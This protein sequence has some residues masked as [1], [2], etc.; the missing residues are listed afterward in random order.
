MMKDTMEYCAVSPEQSFLR[1][2]LGL[3]VC[4]MFVAMVFLLGGTL[5]RPVDSAGSLTQF[6]SES[7]AGFGDDQSGSSPIVHASHLQ[8]RESTGKPP[9]LIAVASNFA[10]PVKDLAKRFELHTGVRL[11]LTFGSTGK[12]FT[13]VMNG[14]PFDA[15]L[16]ADAE[17][18]R[19]L[20]ESGRSVRGSRFVYAVGRLA[21]WTCQR[22]IDLID[23]NVLGDR[24]SGRVAIANPELAPYGLAARQTLESLGY[25]DEIQDRLVFGENIGQAFHFAHSRNARFGFVALSQVL[26]MPAEERGSFWVVPESHHQPILQE[27]ILLKENADA[28]AFLE[29]LK[30]PEAKARI[31]EFGYGVLSIDQ[32][33]SATL[34][35]SF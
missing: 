30:A 27:A 32:E 25:W 11:E 13:Q 34:G 17:R 19:L 2:S 6:Q 18:P 28:R 3:P 24:N 20:E 31:A 22:N 4:A 10:E 26:T 14:A 9:A 16:S 7:V 21:F 33:T 15:L 8:S 1:R 35:N 12:H 23:A 5:W 29:Y